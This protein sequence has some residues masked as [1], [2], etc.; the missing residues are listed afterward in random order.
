MSFNMWFPTWLIHCHTKEFVFVHPFD[1]NPIYLFLF[2]TSVLTMPLQNN[3]NLV[4]CTFND[5]LFQSNHNNR[6]FT[7]SFI[8]VSTCSMFPP[9]QKIFLSSTELTNFNIW[10]FYNVIDTVY[11]IN[12]FES[13]T[14]CWSTPQAMSKYPEQWLPN[15]TNCR[16]SHK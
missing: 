8:S 13:N 15:F 6:F 10:T 2:A 14:D 5:N 12:S 9:A 3:I 16:P 4:L 1:F 11:R 7:W